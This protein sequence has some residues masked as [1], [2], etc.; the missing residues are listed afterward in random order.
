[1]FKL[2]RNYFLSMRRNP[3]FEDILSAYIFTVLVF[4]LS[5]VMLFAMGLFVD[6]VFMALEPEMAPIDTF[7]CF[8]L[9]LFVVDIILKSYFKSN[10]QVDVLPYLTL[11]VPRKKIYTLLFFKDLISGWDFIWVALLIPFFFKTIY[12]VNGLTSTL[13]LIFSVYVASLT[14]SSI[15]R[16][17]NILS[18]WKS[19]Q[20]A[21]LPLLL[22][23]FVGCIA[24][25][26]A[27]APRLLININLLFSQYRIAVF[28]ASIFLFFGVFVIFLKSC[29]RE[30]YTLLAGKKN[31]T[32]A[33]NLSRFTV[34]G[35]KGEMLNL[36][37]REVLRSSLRRMFLLLIL[38]FVVSI[39]LLYTEWGN[40]MTRCLLAM[41]HI[42]L[43]GRIYGEKTFS[44]ESTF[45]D[46]LMTSHKNLPYLILRTKYALCVIHSAIYTVISIIVCINKI[47]VLFWLST[48]S[49]GCGVFLFFFFQSVVYNR[50]QIDILDSQGKFSELSFNTI[51]I[52]ILL[53]L[54]TGL[55]TITIAGL[56][57]ET[58]AEYIMLITGVVGM[59]TSPFWLKNIY[60]RF[61]A[62][63]YRTMSSFRNS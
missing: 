62:R 31:F 42:V 15:I 28:I 14:I 45:F 33:F 25:Y 47:S 7:S 23:A 16:L 17:I 37:L 19:F 55:M 22:A 29:R 57:S 26:V 53:T 56:T 54:S 50:Q 21:F 1:M 40:F 3:V 32:L 59:A 38:S 11:P 60:R 24:W 43:L 51:V 36:C 41:W 9:F 52:I 46:K 49:F 2:I 27:V 30:I 10:I 13:L 8:F 48:F 12:P 35:I 63:K 61:L 58:T 5:Y 44:T 4:S 34:F 39:Y 18:A 20:Y 6:K